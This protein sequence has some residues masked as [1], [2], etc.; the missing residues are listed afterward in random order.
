MWLGLLSSSALAV[1]GE[2]GPVDG[3]VVSRQSTGSGS[4]VGSDE[5]DALR[6]SSPVENVCGVA[7][8][9]A[10][11]GPL[12]GGDGVDARTGRCPGLTRVGADG[13]RGREDARLGGVKPGL[14]KAWITGGV[15]TLKNGFSD[16]MRV[17]AGTL[18]RRFSTN[19]TDNCI[20]VSYD[21]HHLVEWVM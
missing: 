10:D 18:D 9:K 20:W 21:Q 12:L 17:E 7:A 8:L 5:N 14:G 4:D 3:R 15:Q 16:V 11:V 1:G 6:V 2:S 19:C 13:R